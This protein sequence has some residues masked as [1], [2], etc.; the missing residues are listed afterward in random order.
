MDREKGS[1]Q[2]KGEWGGGTPNAF[3]GK[4]MD[5]AYTGSGTKLL[6][7]KSGSEQHYENNGSGE[8]MVS[9]YFHGK[10]GEYF[11]LRSQVTTHKS[12]TFMTIGFAIFSTKRFNIITSQPSILLSTS[13]SL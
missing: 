5:G 7:S 13:L 1:T 4:V 10:G 2:P 9:P 8:L 6:G 11:M 3:N 12:C